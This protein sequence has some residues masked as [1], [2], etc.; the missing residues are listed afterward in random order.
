PISSRIIRVVSDYADLV[1]ARKMKPNEAVED[2]KRQSKKLY[3]NRVVTLLEQFVMRIDP[4]H[5]D[6]SALQLHELEPG[7]VVKRD[8]ITNSGLKLLPAGATLSEAS[9]KTLIKYNTTDPI[10]GDIVV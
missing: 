10:I 6:E 3:D 8:V 1:I 9:I 2:I 5:A 4:A 7:M